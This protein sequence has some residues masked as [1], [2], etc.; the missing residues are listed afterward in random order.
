MPYR[1]LPNTDNSR[2]NALNT[3]FEKGQE[4]PPFKLAFSQQTL[5][6]LKSFLPKYK[7]AILTYKKTYENQVKNN[8]D[9]LEK[10]RKAK[11]FISHFI[12]VVNMAITRGEI[13]ANT[14]EYYGLE[15]YENKVPP[16]NTETAIME[17]GKKLIDGEN[18]RKNK[19]MAPITNPTIAVVQVRY[20]QYVDAYRFQKTLQQDHKRTLN[21]LSALRKEAG[22]IIVNIWNEVEEAFA[23][24]PNETKRTKAAEYGVV[25]VYRKNEV[26]KVDTNIGNI[27]TA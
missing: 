19:G 1:R 20:D 25:Y 27:T 9:Y 18:T 12:Q 26:R 5:N 11:L 14:R 17:W 22:N 15:N 2:I 8:N 23:D 3:A 13:K 21:E 6:Q 16:L 24:L 10:Q 4:L 7:Q